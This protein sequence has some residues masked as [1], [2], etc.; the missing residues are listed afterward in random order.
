M[1]HILT[2]IKQGILCFIATSHAKYI[3]FHNISLT[4]VKG[5]YGELKYILITALTWFKVTLGDMYFRSLFIMDKW[6]N[7]NY[8][9]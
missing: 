5:I 4:H 6:F 2:E 1:E 8:E 7:E 9:F 3:R